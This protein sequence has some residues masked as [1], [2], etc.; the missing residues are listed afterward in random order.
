MT[1]IKKESNKQLQP[2]LHGAKDNYEYSPAQ[3]HN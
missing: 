1:Y 2:E 3:N